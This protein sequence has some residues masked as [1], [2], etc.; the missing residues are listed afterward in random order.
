M[1]GKRRDTRPGVGARLPDGSVVE[2]VQ[3]DGA[4][5]FLRSSDGK[6]E[7][8]S[9]V[10]LETGETLVPYSAS[11][12][13]LTHRVVLFPSAVAEYGTAADLF[14]AVRSFIH[15]Y[16]DISEAFE[17]VAAQY[18]LFSWRYD[19]FT[20]LPY[21]R[22]RGD[23]GSG[24]S[25]FLQVVGSLCYRPIFASGA[26]TVSPIFRILDAVQ[27]TLVIDEGDFRVSDEKAEIIKILNNGNARGFPV[28]RSEAT[29]QKEFNPKAFSVYGPKII[30]TRRSFHD[31]ALES[32]CLT[33]DMGKRTL[34][35]DI[36]LSLPPTFE[37]EAL[38]LR[39]QLLLYRFQTLG[40]SGKPSVL[41]NGEPR[42][43]QVLSPLLAT[44]ETTEATEAIRQFASRLSGTLLH[45]RSNSLEGAVLAVLFE[46][47][48]NGQ[49][50][51]VKAVADALSIRLE[52][53]ITPRRVG[54]LLRHRLLLQPVKRRGVFVIPEEEHETLLHLFRRHGLLPKQDEADG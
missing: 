5:A 48:E 7:R 42:V 16:V 25:R 35:P 37:A 23:Y 26:S 27:G 9:T 21:L 33:E 46:L 6:I 36:P 13:L 30:A 3:K 31:E 11:N 14:R 4:T 50:L 10:K 8:I 53:T 17:A 52:E 43:K 24:K 34:R 18:V 29:P 39:N 2:L 49:T 44:A 40:S 1:S 41:E 28:L 32:R 12:N 22:V 15:R 54:H 20:E 19:D 47:K 45:R 51:S 38:H